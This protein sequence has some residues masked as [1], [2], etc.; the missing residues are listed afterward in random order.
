MKLVKKYSQIVVQLER[1]GQ[2]HALLRNEAI[3]V[4]ELLKARSNQSA[5]K[6]V[7]ESITKLSRYIRSTPVSSAG[8][9]LRPI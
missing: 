5:S 3:D 1:L 8:Q 4:Y 6:K 2:S 9:E 7:A